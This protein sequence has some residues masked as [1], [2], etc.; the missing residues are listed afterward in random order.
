MLFI[1]AF[2]ISM[3]LLRIYGALDKSPLMEPVSPQ[4]KPAANV[5]LPATNAP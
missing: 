3:I 1:I 4:N 5:A 2:I